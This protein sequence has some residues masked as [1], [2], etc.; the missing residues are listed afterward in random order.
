MAASPRTLPN[1]VAYA[2]I[3]ITRANA[4]QATVSLGEPDEVLV[5]VEVT[6]GHIP[7]TARRE[8]VDAIFALPE[9]RRRHRL[10]AAVPVGDWELL[11]AFAH[12]F[13]AISTRAAGAT[14]L[15]DARR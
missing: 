14:C 15:V 12:H 4:V 5:A 2:P 3:H 6:A 8:L 1:A 10:R 11:D 13:P 7:V 9:V